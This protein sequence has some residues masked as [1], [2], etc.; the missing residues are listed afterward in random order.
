MARVRTPVGAEVGATPENPPKT[1]LLGKFCNFKEEMSRE[2]Y[3]F[4]LHGVLLNARA[5]H[6]H[7]A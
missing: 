3:S 1:L 7:H 6:P 2:K 4:L 5:G